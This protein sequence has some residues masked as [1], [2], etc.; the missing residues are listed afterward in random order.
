M[1]KS[2]APVKATIAGGVIV[3]IAAVTLGL[4]AVGDLL[5]GAPEPSQEDLALAQGTGAGAS[6]EAEEDGEEV[7]EAAA[8]AAPAVPVVEDSIVELPYN[9]PL[10]PVLPFRENP[11][12]VVTEPGGTT[13]QG[14]GYAMGERLV[15]VP[16]TGVWMP[17]S[18]AEAYQRV[19]RLSLDYYQAIA[20]ANFGAR[21]DWGQNSFPRP[22]GVMQPVPAEPTPLLVQPAS[23]FG[24]GGSAVGPVGPAEGGTAEPGGPRPGVEAQP[25]DQVGPRVQPKTN[26]A[27][28]RRV[29]GIVHDGTAVAIVE[30]EAAGAITRM[31]VRPGETFS[32]GDEEFRVRAIAEGEIVLVQTES[33]EEV[34]VPL[35]G[36]AANE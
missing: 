19:K 8:P 23:F 15:R 3:A 34:R 28:I 13:P 22:H 9:D 20:D 30:V 24:P 11:F 18:D 35:R 26:P 12:E 6:A 33:D 32:V 2:T 7:E 1:T 31:R 16:Y 21:F 27:R 10:T 14:P 17:E 29:A 25:V 4:V 36:R 5:L